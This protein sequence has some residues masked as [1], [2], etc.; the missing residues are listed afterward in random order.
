MVGSPR[1]GPAANAP[2]LRSVRAGEYLDQRW[3]SG[4]IRCAGPRWRIAC[5]QARQHAIPPQCAVH[6]IVMNPWS[7]AQPDRYSEPRSAVTITTLDAAADDI[8]RDQLPDD[9]HAEP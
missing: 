5:L 3:S 6:P 1:S 4:K 9:D 2:G 8:D 7:R